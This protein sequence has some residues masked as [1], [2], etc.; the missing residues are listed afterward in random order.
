VIWPF[1]FFSENRVQW[2]QE[3][4]GIEFTGN[5]IV[6]TSVPPLDLYEKLTTGQGLTIEL[7]LETAD[8][9]QKGPAR[10]VSYSLNPGSRNF[11]L[12]QEKNALI[13]RL[14][15]TETDMNGVRPHLVVENVFNKRND[16]LHIVVTYDWTKQIV[17]VNGIMCMAKSIPGG[18]FSN[19]DPTHYLILGNEGTCNRP[20]RG[21]LRHISF[22]NRPLDAEEVYSLFHKNEISRL[23]TLDKRKPNRNGIITEYRFS[24]GNGNSIHGAKDSEI[25]LDFL[26]PK[27]ARPYTAPFLRWPS[28]NLVYTLNH[29]DTLLNVLGFILFGFLGHGMMRNT[30]FL[31]W[32]ISIFVL[33][34]GI[35]LSFF[36]ESMQY[37]SVKRDS[38]AIDFCANSIG[39]V[40]G[41]YIDWAYIRHVKQFWEKNTNI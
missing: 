30:Y 1:D 38:S 36:F 29:R 33:I 15:T 5:G 8:I 19:W 31:S 2:L 24:E 7:W 27:Y 20:W 39:T 37:F 23:N 17:F 6:M 40:L 13:V 22:Y 28:D 21:K 3:T 34:T 12:G 10:I 35:C 25:A 16:L 4:N 11:T 32:R 18:T 14:R 9:G 26:I 41:I